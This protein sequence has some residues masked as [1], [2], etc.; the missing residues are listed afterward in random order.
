MFD[1]IL[2]NARLA[3][4]RESRPVWLATRDGRIAA[5]GTGE[6]PEARETVDC[7]RDWLMAPFADSHIHLRAVA[8]AARVLDLVTDHPADLPELFRLL[9]ARADETPAV[10]RGFDPSAVRERRW[11][12]VTELD[13]LFPDAPCMVGDAGGHGAAINTVAAER[14]GGWASADVAGARPEYVGGAATGYIA[15]TGRWLS[16]TSL[17]VPDPSVADIEAV[18]NALRGLGVTAVCDATPGSSK[19]FFQ[20]LDDAA[21]RVPSVAV[22]GMMSPNARWCES[23]WSWRHLLPGPRKIFLSTVTGS[24]E[25]ASE[26]LERILIRAGRAGETVAVHAVALEETAHLLGAL[27]AIPSPDRPRVRLEHGSEL[28]DRAIEG[29]SAMNVAVVTQPNFIWRHGP[30]YLRTV[31]KAA[32]LLLYR[33][34]SLVDAGVNVTFSSDAPAG[35]LDPWEDVIAAVHR[36]DRAGNPI[37]VEDESLPAEAAL[38]RRTVAA[39]KL[40]RPDIPAWPE[41]GAPAACLRLAENPLVSVKSGRAPAF[42]APLFEVKGNQESE[43][44]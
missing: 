38:S 16:L 6:P 2:S 13:E 1:R 40:I 36:I 30:R 11:P 23:N 35:G 27:D 19:A 25:P 39:A 3:T 15:E 9:A 10:V 43:I 22:Q 29:L 44:A 8:R 12:G 17:G 26:E 37:P 20:L 21:S 32:Q 24:M 14:L 18:L 5:S 42:I 33:F 7:G 4:S 31:P 28:D 34:R 41:V